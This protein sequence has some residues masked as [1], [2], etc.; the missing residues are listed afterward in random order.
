[1]FEWGKRL[2][3]NLKD[4]DLNNNPVTT[5]LIENNKNLLKPNV[6]INSEKNSL[7]D[8]KQ[9]NLKKKT[10]NDLVS[11]IVTSYN[12]E[13]YIYHTLISLVSQSYK[14]I[15]ILI[16]DDDSTDDTMN[17]LRQFAKKDKRIKVIRND[18]NYGT[19]ISKNIGIKYAKGEFI[20][21]NDA[22]QT[23]SYKFTFCIFNTDIFR[24]IRSIIFIISYDFNSFIFFCKLS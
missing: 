2:K 5:K 20:T 19:Y 7:K 21:F 17:I 16:I 24:Y 14:N 22:D 8:N 23:Q 10:I 11:I 6:K 13:K 3:W 18:K 1:V 4:F 9:E 15:E 12:C